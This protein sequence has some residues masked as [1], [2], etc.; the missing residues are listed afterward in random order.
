MKKLVIS[1]L[2]LSMVFTFTACGGGEIEETLKAF[3]EFEATDFEGNEVNNSI[4]EKYDVTV[5]NFWS[6]GC[7]S[8]IEEMPYLEELYQSLKDKN[9]NFIGVGV[10]SRDTED[11]FV[12]AKEV[13]SKKGV[14][15]MNISPKFESSFKD[16]FITTITGYP[17]TVL[18]DKEGNI[19]GAGLTGVVEKQE[20]NILSRIE[21]MLTNN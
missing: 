1:L 21:N 20:E 3:P 6:N 10:D 18:V 15:Y 12:F 11:N 13:I 5:V 4:F 14:T 2:I 19:R 16:D 9:V 7:G 17:Y 8:C